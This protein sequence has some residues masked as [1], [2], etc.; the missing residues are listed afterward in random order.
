MNKFYLSIFDLDG[1]LFDTSKVNYLSYKE[2]LLKFGKKIPDY[3]DFNLLSHGSNYKVFLKKFDTT[4]AEDEAINIHE[5]KKKL[6]SKYLP[7]AVKNNYLFEIIKSL[8]ESHYISIATTAS[9]KN[10]ND[11]LNYFNVT[12][13]FS[14]IVT[15][16]DV[17]NLKPDPECFFKIINYF[18][19]PPKYTTIFEDSQIGFQAA[20]KTKANLFMVSSFSDAQV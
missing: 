3:N 1:T 17:A 9:K 7:H 11:L 4:I 16:D 12:D 14:M 13:L 6:Y 8:S 19:I 18:N 15:Q 5:D 10:T 2:A 20:N